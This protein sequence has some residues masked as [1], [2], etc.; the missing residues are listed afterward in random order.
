MTYAVIMAGGAG[1]RF[2]PKS[3]VSRPKQFVSLFG[4]QTMIQK[5]IY[6]LKGFADPENTV[7]VTNESYIPIVQKQVPE[8]KHQFIIGEKVARNTAPCV[9]AAAALLY[10]KDPDAVMAVLP[11]DHEI[12]NPKEFLSVLR[13][14]AELAS[15]RDSLV[16]IGIQPNRPETGYGYIRRKEE[17]LSGTGGRKG[18]PVMNFTEKPDQET[19]ESFLA[20]GDYYWNSGMFIWKVSVIVEAFKTHLPEIY[21]GMEKL[22]NSEKSQQDMD[23]F[24]L[25]C[26]SISID[27]GIMEKAEKVDVIPAEFGWNDVGSWTAVHELSE[28]DENLNAV[29]SAR[30]VFLDSRSNLVHSESGKLIALVGMENIAVIETDDAVLVLPLEQAQSVK[31][32]Y[33]EIKKDPDKKGFL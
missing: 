25:G 5:T 24:Y 9:A 16:T 14:A 19:A 26:P 22:M 27:Y 13:S 20:S 28:K 21:A 31:E 11:A 12:G 17:E 10:E 15:A 7:V 2:W 6:R 1:T 29:G 23:G 8:L 30:A 18:Y 33:E 32:L 4:E 3:R